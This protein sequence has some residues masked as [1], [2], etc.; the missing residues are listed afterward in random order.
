[1]KHTRYFI[2]K[3][4]ETFI[5]RSLRH[6]NLLFIRALSNPNDEGMVNILTVIPFIQSLKS[7]AN[8]SFSPIQDLDFCYEK[9]ISYFKAD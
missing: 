6:F 5:K 3:E 2:S 8:A 1:M 7:S 9:A 4:C